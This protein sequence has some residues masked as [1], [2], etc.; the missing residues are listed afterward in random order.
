MTGS[1]RSK[2]ID[3]RRLRFAIQDHG[4]IAHPLERADQ[5]GITFAQNGVAIQHGTHI[6]IRHT[7]GGADNAFAYFVADNFSARVH[8]HDARQHQ[9]LDLRTQAANVRREFE[10]EHGHGAVG[11]INA[12]AAQVRFVIEG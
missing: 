11:E 12:G 7:L 2:S 9:T 6:G 1:G 3:P 4:Q 10:R 5:W 8:F